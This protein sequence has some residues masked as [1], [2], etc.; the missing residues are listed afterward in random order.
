MKPLKNKLII[1]IE[2][3]GYIKTTSSGLSYVKD[4][5]WQVAQ[6]GLVI[7]TGEEVKD[8]KSGDMVHFASHKGTEF[9]IEDIKYVILEEEDCLAMEVV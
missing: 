6:A 4:N 7:E 3:E 9:R 5:P 8:I 2:E 1:K